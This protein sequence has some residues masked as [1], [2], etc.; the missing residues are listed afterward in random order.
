MRIFHIYIVYN[1]LEVIPI[2][3][4]GALKYNPMNKL[5]YNTFSLDFALIT[6]AKNFGCSTLQVFCGRTHRRDEFIFE[7]RIFLNKYDD[8]AVEMVAFISTEWTATH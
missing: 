1:T 4:P 2:R 7:M 8:S 5:S 6:P 3:I